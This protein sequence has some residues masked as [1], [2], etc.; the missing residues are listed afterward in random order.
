MVDGGYV[1]DDMNDS[2]FVRL[3]MLIEKDVEM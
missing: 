1:D 2:I 3:L